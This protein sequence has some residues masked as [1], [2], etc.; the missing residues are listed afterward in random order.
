MS[1]RTKRSELRRSVTV[2]PPAPT[3]PTLLA[4]VVAAQTEVER[5][6]RVDLIGVVHVERPLVV[7]VVAQE[8]RRL[9]WQRDLVEREVA[10]WVDGDAERHDLTED[11]V[12]ERL[13]EAPTEL[14]DGI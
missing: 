10:L 4:E 9:Q 5:E 6:A 11:Q 3:G 7:P 14:L 1:P 8:V 13:A 2:P 12:V